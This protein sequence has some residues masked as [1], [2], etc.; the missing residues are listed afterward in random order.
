MSRQVLSDSDIARSLKRI[1]H[2]IL[3]RNHGAKDIVLLGIPTRGVPLAHRIAEQ[4]EATESRTLT[5]L[6]G[7]APTIWKSPQSR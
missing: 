7:E 3:E 4:I 5:M 6:S 1:A 2:E